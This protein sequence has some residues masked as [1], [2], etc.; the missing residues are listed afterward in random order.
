MGSKG[1][2]NGTRHLQIPSFRCGSLLINI[3]QSE[4]PTFDGNRVKL[5]NVSRIRPKNTSR[6]PPLEQ[7]VLTPFSKISYFYTIKV[8]KNTS[9]DCGGRLGSPPFPCVLQQKSGCQSIRVRAKLYCGRGN[10]QS[11][12]FRIRKELQRCLCSGLKHFK[13]EHSLPM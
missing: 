12:C 9:V 13:K 4:G 10:L 7:E 3:N 11:L 1:H 6:E 8:P 2:C 5:T